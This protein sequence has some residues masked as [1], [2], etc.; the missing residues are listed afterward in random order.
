[1]PDRHLIVYDNSDFLVEVAKGLI[2][3]H[4]IVH[5]Y[6][7]NHDIDTGSVPES[8]WG[9]GGLY[10]GFNAVAAQTVNVT[11]TH[12]DDDVGG[13]GALRVRLEG[14]DGNY[15]RVT[16]D[17]TLTGAIA[18]VSGNTYL[19]LDRAYVLTAGAAGCNVGDIEISQTISGI[20][21]VDLPATRNQAN[22]GCYTVPA[23]FTAWP[24]S[25][26]CTLI[27]AQDTTARMDVFIRE[28]GGVFRSRFPFGIYRG[29]GPVTLATNAPQAP[30]L[31][32]TDFDVRCITTSSSNTHVTIKIDFLLVDNRF[33]P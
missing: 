8:L 5:K 19:R 28:F 9:G 15:D 14:L 3:G 31:E 16:E 24:L 23:G 27:D 30:L 12:G 26:L 7:G 13:D 4:S 29:G 6:G 2:P 25:G 21:M 11:S 22:M 17:V 10:P 33:L 1:M 18:T 20:K 32:K